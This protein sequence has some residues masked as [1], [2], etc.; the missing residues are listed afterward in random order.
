MENKFDMK[1]LYK[2]I[3]GLGFKK[4]E[5]KTILPE[6]WNDN[7]AKTQTGFL[8]AAALLSKSLSINFNS[9]ISDEDAYFDLPLT[10]FKS[11]SNI[12][13]S[14][15]NAA[16]AL[17]TVAAKATLRGFSA[18]KKYLELTAKDVRQTLLSRGNRWIDFRTLVEYCWEIGIPVLHLS[19]KNHKKMQGLAIEINERPVIILTSNLKYGYLVFDLAHELGHILAGHTKDSLIID[20]QISP[21]DIDQKEKEANDIAL[22]ILTGSASS[23]STK[24]RD[25]NQIANTCILTGKERNIDP[26]HLAL[27]IGHS[28]G[29]WALANTV[30]KMIK[31]KLNIGANDPDICKEAMLERLDFD[32][33][34][35]FE[36]PMRMITSSLNKAA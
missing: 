36:H 5:I 18:D 29:N 14:D 9:L 3:I 21:S 35:D 26:A 17:S 6:W 23:F 28:M 20:E 13:S 34:G 32:A 1:N 4:K 12:Q 11:R 25:Y 2:K 24:I 19:L 10:N 7:I 33:M 8:E 27:N 16:V 15:L 30:L 31:Q 22:E